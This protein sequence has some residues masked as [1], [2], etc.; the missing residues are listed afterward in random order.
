MN[1]KELTK[2]SKFLSLV[3]RHKPET[4]G[5]G[6]SLDKNGWLDIG[7]LISRAYQNCRMKISY[8]DIVEIV[9][10]NDKKRFEYDEEKMRIRASQGH[11]IDVDIDL[12]EKEPPVFLYHGTSDRFLETIKQ[13]GL[14]PMSRQYVHLS[15]DRVTAEKVGKRHGG[16]IVV[17]RIRAD[18]YKYENPE[19][20]FYLSRNGVWLT[21]YIPPEY[22]VFPF[23]IGMDKT[24]RGFT[25]TDF[26]DMY[27]VPCSLQQSSLATENALWLGVNDADP[28]IMACKVNGGIPDGWAKYPVPE[29]VHFTTRM[30][31]SEEMV[32]ALIDKLQNWLDTGELK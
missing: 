1:N 23:E 15:E 5:K 21:D 11:S 6:V 32:A 24:E 14:K 8:D 20:K 16:N 31:L 17:L 18:E 26:I 30:H 27:D 2:K 4:L 12:E 25:R 19:I 10:T 22:I 28:K 29:D 7:V 13:E 9:D 3:L